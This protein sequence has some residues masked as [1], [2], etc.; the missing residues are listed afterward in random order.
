MQ[1]NFQERLDCYLMDGLLK[2]SICALY[3]LYE[4]HDVI[5]KENLIVL[6]PLINEEELSAQ[7]HVEFIE[8]TLT[9]YSKTLS[10]VVVLIA[11]NCSTNRKIS[12]TLEIPLLG[13]T[14]HRFNN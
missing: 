10:N 11:E 9:M 14:S 8:A 4:N 6:A 5:H 3:A 12:N 7:K 13:C 1:N 2:L